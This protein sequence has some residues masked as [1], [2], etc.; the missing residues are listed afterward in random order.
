MST[1]L[2]L[3]DLPPRYRAQAEKQIAD[4]S[5]RKAPAG[6][7]S[8]EVAAKT[9]GEIGKVFESKGEYDFYIGTVLP[10]I[11]SGRIIK[12]TPHV[13]FPLL[14]AKDFCAVH[15][16]AAR[17]TADY[18]LEYADGTVEV[19]EIKSKF[20]RRAQRDYI[21]R[22]RL[23]IDLIAEPRGYV[24]RE[25]ITTDTKTEIKEWKRLA[26]QAGKE[27]SWAK[28]E[29]GCPRTTDRASRTP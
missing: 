7:V 11:Q 18:V 28:A 12:A 4:R 25:I 19:V 20:T 13:A 14:P 9:A 6:A 1:R 3:E 21:Y 8:L 27:S 22:R 26:D 24:F 2:E 5:A 17:Y 29:Q 10:G 23:F 15:L 16:P